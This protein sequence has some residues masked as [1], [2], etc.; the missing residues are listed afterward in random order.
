MAFTL[1]INL[2]EWQLPISFPASILLPPASGAQQTQAVG[3]HKLE[4]LL[5][6]TKSP[7]WPQFSTH[8]QL[9]LSFVWADPEATSNYFTIV[10]NVAPEIFRESSETS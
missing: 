10:N 5:G 2:T 8:E 9:I 4:K 3:T 1:H 7:N 6:L